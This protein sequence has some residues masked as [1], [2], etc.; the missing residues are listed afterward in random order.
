MRSRCIVEECGNEVAGPFWRN[1]HAAMTLRRSAW[2][3]S[4]ACLT[5]ILLRVALAG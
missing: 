5:D 2:L 4:S 1:Y 3:A